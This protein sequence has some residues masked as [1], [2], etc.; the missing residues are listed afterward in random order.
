MK[1]CLRSLR[2]FFEFALLLLALSCVSGAQEKSYPILELHAQGSKL[3]SDE[4]IVKATGLRVDTKEE[5]SLTKVREAAERLVD[6]GVFAEVNYQHTALRNGMKVQ[7]T[8]QDKPADQFVPT[9]LG[10]FV[11]WPENQLV[12]EL[13]SRLPLYGG[14]LPL[15]GSLADEVAAELENGD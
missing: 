8:V 4:E 15:G 11:W 1:M 2:Q 12:S 10:N 5:I 6:S 7:F 13:H 3:F 14:R 9:R